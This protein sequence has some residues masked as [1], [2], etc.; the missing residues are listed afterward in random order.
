MKD[1][2]NGKIMSEF[3]GLRSKLYAFKV[4][5]D[6]KETRKAKGVK[7]STLK[8]ITFEDYKQSLFSYKNLVKTQFLI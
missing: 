8:E 7:W 1:E 4:Q 2:N 3:I 5:G 6:Q